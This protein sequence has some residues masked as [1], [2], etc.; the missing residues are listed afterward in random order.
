VD[1]AA[2]CVHDDIIQEVEEIH[3]M[4]KLVS[5]VA[6]LAAAGAAQAAF[7]EVRSVDTSSLGS[8]ISTSSAL[9]QSTAAGNST[10]GGPSADAI[11][12]NQASW[13][14]A[15]AANQA[16]AYD[17]YV[18]IDVGPSFGGDIDVKGDGFQA[19]PGD[20]SSIGNPFGAANSIS[21][22]WFM[23]PAGP[24]PIVGSV[25]NALF[26][27]AD[28]LFVGRFTFRA[29]GG[30]IPNGT[31]TLGQNG[32]AIDIR[33]PGTLGVGSPATDTLILNFTSFNT[34]VQIGLDAGSLTN[35]AAAYEYELRTVVTN[36]GPFG[37]GTARFQVHDMYIVQIPTPGATALLGL[38]G[39]AAIRRRRA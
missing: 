39:L 12:G 19:N 22:L 38:A 24:R 3:V 20:L 15:S 31:L 26:G 9:F 27:G 11:E 23:D 29:T 1:P 35:H 34:P 17:S 7:F 36:V 18:A 2:S 5:A 4:V 13:G 16:L 28:A 14:L 8:P 37:A 30:A 32:V 33:D 21:A 10:I 25:N 6:L